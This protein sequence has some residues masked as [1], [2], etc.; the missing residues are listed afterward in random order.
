MDKETKNRIADFFEAWDLIEFLQVSVDDVL[1]SFED[2]IV[3]A[4]DDI[5]ELMGVKND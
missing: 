1:D 4:L 5:E 3:E 2:E